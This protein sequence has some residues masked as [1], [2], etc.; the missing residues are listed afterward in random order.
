MSPFSV[1]PH[2][3]LALTCVGQDSALSVLCCEREVR[4]QIVQCL[5]EKVEYEP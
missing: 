4:K 1:Q 3:G 5:R 2:S